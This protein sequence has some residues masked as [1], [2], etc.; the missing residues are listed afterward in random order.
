MGTT[1]RRILGDDM[2]QTVEERVM[3]KVDENLKMMDFKLNLILEITNDIKEHNQKVDEDIRKLDV[4]AGYI[5][6]GLL[7]L[8]TLMGYGMVKLAP[9]LF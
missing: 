7:V 5:K 2:R 3:E 1:R 6:G 4:F 9:L 8:T